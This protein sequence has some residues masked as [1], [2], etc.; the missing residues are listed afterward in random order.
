MAVDMG[1]AA[2]GAG[3]GA[4]AGA[5]FGPWGAVIGGVVGLGASLIGGNKAAGQRK[6]MED[7]LNRQD[8]ENK[9]F[10]NA[11]ALSDYTQRTDVQ[12]LMKQ[13]RD[14]LGRQNKTIA[15][16]AVVTGATPEQQ[17][18]AKEQANKAISDTYA[19]IGAMGRQWKDRVTD[20]YLSRRESIANQ[21]MNIM[22]GKAQSGENLQSNGLNMLG[23]S[24]GSLLSM[25][26]K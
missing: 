8:T 12:N 14:N 2:S 15:N 18:V 9:S 11:N 21:R 25:W 10:Y 6:L 4:A 16:T 17:A 13:L 23:N 1:S 24:A 5:A 20:R 26:G 22:Q 19:N 3:K 7:Y